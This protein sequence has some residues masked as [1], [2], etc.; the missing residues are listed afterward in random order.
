MAAKK[1]K[2][3]HAPI[4]RR[5]AVRLRER[6]AAAGLT[7]SELA[8]RAELSTNYVNRLEAAGAAP[9]IDTLERLADA[10]KT[11]A[12]DLLPARE[13]P[14]RMAAAAARSRDLLERVINN[15]EPELILALVP[16]LTR[17]AESPGPVN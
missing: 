1:Q 9:G 7:Q 13:P 15:P 3:E 6:R 14:D 2:N 4:V 16:I 5:F 8:E 17:L 12:H 10:L 11:T